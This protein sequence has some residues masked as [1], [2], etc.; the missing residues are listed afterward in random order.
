[1]AIKEI[2]IGKKYK[3]ELLCIHN[4]GKVIMFETPTGDHLPFRE[5]DLECV[6]PAAPKYDPC[7]PF[8]KGDKV[9]VKKRDGRCNG[10]AGEYL[11]EAFCTVAE[12]ETPNEL[13]RVLHNS[14]EY[15]LAP[16]YLELITPAEE[17]DTAPNS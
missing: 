3:L 6:S 2:K 7:R 16:A 14:T 5:S 9:Q 12:D 17:L 11:R 13:V 4:A 10:K 15:R 1:M 8:R